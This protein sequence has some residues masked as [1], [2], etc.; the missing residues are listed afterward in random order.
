M[1]DEEKEDRLNVPE[2]MIGDGAAQTGDDPFYVVET[3]IDEREELARQIAA[4][5][6]IPSVIRKPAHLILVKDSDDDPPDWPDF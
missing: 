6:D 3:D 5:P 2:E 1:N 4:E